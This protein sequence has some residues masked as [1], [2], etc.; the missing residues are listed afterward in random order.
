MILNIKKVVIIMNRVVIIGSGPAGLFC[1]LN[2]KKDN[3][4]VIILEKKETFGKKILVTGSGKCNYWN[5]DQDIKHYHSRSSNNL[6]TII[7]SSNLDD[8]LNILNNYIVPYVRDGY[9]YP[10]SREASS[11]RDILVE[12]CLKIGVSFK[13]NFEVKN[14]LYEDGMFIINNELFCSQ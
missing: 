8:T 5:S 12:E 2:A 3:N 7:N 10:Y 11:V 13:N 4:E 6:S 1:A 14:V 9:Y